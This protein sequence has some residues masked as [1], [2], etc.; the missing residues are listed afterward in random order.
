MKYFCV[1][2]VGL[3][4]PINQDSYMCLSNEGED[5]LV[6]VCDGIGG[7]KAGEVA[8]GEVIQTFVD[9]FKQISKFHSLA[10]ADEFL[11]RT[12]LKANLHI[13]K[14]A[15]QNPEYRGMGTTITGILMTEHGNVTINVG[16]S[17]VY[18]ID[19]KMSCL[20]EDHTLVNEMLK[21]GEI[22]YEESLN[23]PKKHFL[24]AALGIFER[25]YPDIKIVQEAAYYLVC[26]DGLHGFVPHEKIEKII[27]NPN[28]NIE[29][30]TNE[31]LQAALLEGGYDNITI[32]LVNKDV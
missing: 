7:S 11:Y 6:L 8:S 25:I 15:K 16:D 9:E 17:R 28:K 5:L 30:K 23:H 19:E 10:Q 21:S 18:K 1:S 24:T 3:M 4:R 20:T 13:Y 2:D 32:V 27:L 31:L 26:S 29:E 14:L 12:C 22:T